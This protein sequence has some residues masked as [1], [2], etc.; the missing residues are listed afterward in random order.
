MGYGTSSCVSTESNC[1]FV[2]LYAHCVAVTESEGR[3]CSKAHR[4]RITADTMLTAEISSSR[5]HPTK[6]RRIREQMYAEPDDGGD[7]E[8]TGLVKR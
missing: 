1:G 4:P 2:K 5:Y 7:G 8:E 3:A 6:N